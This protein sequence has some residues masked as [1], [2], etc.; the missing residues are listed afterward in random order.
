MGLDPEGDRITEI[1]GRQPNEVE[2]GMF[3]V[4]WS[5]HCSYKT[6]RMC[7]GIFPPKVPGYPGTRENAGVVDIGDG[8]ALVLRLSHNHPSAIEPYQGCNRVAK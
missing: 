2:L 1:L 5:E 3:S 8:Q 4:M 7:C 6:L